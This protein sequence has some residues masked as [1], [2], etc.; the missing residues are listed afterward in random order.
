MFSSSYRPDPDCFHWFGLRGH[1]S[2]A[3]VSRAAPPSTFVQIIRRANDPA[4][5]ATKFRNK[6]APLLGVKSIQLDWNYAHP[7]PGSRGDTGVCL[8]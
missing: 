8:G 3:A 6:V 1:S 4:A 2:R 5:D 7:N